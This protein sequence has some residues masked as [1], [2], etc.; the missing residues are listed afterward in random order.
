R[1]HRGTALTAIAAVGTPLVVEAQELVEV[2]LQLIERV[3]PLLAKGL[4]KELVLERAM[5]TLDEAVRPGRGPLRRAVLDALGAQ[6]DLVEVLIGTAA[7]L[8][9]V[10]RQHGLHLDPESVVKGQD[11][12][13][14]KRHGMDRLLR[15]AKTR[16]PYGTGAINGRLRVDPTYSLDRADKVQVLADELAWL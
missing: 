16:E 11:L 4:G 8:A 14:Y 15:D 6:V 9:P 5:E 7:E 10:V 2:G 12:L 1:F 3:V 13:M